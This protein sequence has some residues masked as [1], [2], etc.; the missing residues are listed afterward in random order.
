MYRE[1]QRDMGP[2]RAVHIALCVFT[3]V[4]QV[5]MCF[6]YDQTSGYLLSTGKYH[7]S[8]ASIVT[9]KHHSS[10]AALSLVPTALVTILATD[11]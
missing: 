1:L 9:G 4:L 2:Y 6:L 11:S 8:V 5:N 10:G 3:H 7:E